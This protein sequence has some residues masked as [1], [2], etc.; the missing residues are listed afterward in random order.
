MSNNNGTPLFAE[1]RRDE[2]VQMLTQHTKLLVPELCTHFG[3]SPATIRNDLRDL[4]VEGKLRRTH[5]GAIPLGKTAFE[6]DSSTKEVEHIE[7][8]RRIAQVAASLVEDGDTIALDTGTTTLELA[9]CLTQKQNLT[10]LTNDIMIAT[11]LEVNS[12]ANLLVVGGS[13]RRHFHCTLGPMAV[14]GLASFNVD[15]AFMASNAFSLDKGFTTPSVELA[16]TK[17]TMISIAAQVHMLI[18]SSKV[19]RV[20]FTKFA[21]LADIDKLIT[22]TGISDSVRQVIQDSTDAELLIA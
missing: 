16:E 11:W 22:D 18:D 6:P 13:L 17:R 1:E 21:D 2:I 15:K 12:R 14:N 5:G 9:K 10:I 8:K 7:E 19:R 20:S 3:V 4:E